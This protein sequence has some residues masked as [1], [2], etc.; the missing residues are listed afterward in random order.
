MNGLLST[1]VFS[2]RKG[3]DAFNGV[4]S[5]I[6]TMVTE[7]DR[8]LPGALT[9][10]LPPK[11]G[12]FNDKLDSAGSGGSDVTVDGG[13]D[14]TV[15]G[16]RDVTVDGGSDVTVD[17]GRDVTVDGGS[18]VT[19]DGGSDVTVDGG[20]DVTADGGGDVTADGGGDVTVDGASDVMACAA[21]SSWAHSA[22]AGSLTSYKG[23][24]NH[25]PTSTSYYGNGVRWYK[26]TR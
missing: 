5:G 23:L 12:S 18:D 2:T 20:R 21:N 17:G 25:E 3:L 4:V 11:G 15:D 19:V 1:S 10:P 26:V 13:S 16:V 24:T 8:R 22:C 7:R 9:S 6:A 14:V